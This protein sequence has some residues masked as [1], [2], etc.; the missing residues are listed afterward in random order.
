MFW[1]KLPGLS[2]RWAKLSSKILYQFSQTAGNVPKVSVQDIQW[3][4]AQ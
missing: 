1:F 4:D 2:W 3:C